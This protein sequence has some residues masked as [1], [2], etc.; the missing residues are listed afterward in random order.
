M[1][2]QKKTCNNS[3]IMPRS[4]KCQIS[5][6]TFGGFQLIVDLD[7]YYNTKEVCEYV[8]EKLIG[9]LNKLHLGQLSVQAKQ[10]NFHI[11]DKDIYDLR[12]G[13]ENDIIYVCAHC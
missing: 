8:R 9:S 1:F 5:D 11:H 4:R 13:G 3:K 10:K 6:E 7:F 12:K 2:K